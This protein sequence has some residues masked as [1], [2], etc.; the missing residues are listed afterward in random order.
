YTDSV[1]KTTT[2]PARTRATAQDTESATPERSAADVAPVL[3]AVPGDLRHGAVRFVERGAD[4]IAERGDAEH[5]PAVGHHAVRRAARGGV[6]HHAVRPTSQRLQSLNAR[7]LFYGPRISLR[8][9]HD[10]HRRTRIPL[11]LEA[12]QPAG[13]R[14]LGD[15]EEIGTQPQQDGLR[16]RVAEAH[17]ELEHL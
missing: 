9:Q 3:H 13:G 12:R 17:V 10:A 1:G 14:T 4:R 16:F 6:E 7:A 8:R 2:P 5:A 15:L 11:D